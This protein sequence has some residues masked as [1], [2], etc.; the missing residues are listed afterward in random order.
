M[1]AHFFYC[2]CI[3]KDMPLCGAAAPT[4]LIF[5]YPWCRCNRQ[6]VRVF[7]LCHGVFCFATRLQFA[8]Q[9][10][11]LTLQTKGRLCERPLE[12]RAKTFHKSFTKRWRT[13]CR[14]CCRH[15]LAV[16]V[17][18]AY[19]AAKKIRVLF[20]RLADSRWGEWF[21]AYLRCRK[22][23]GLFSLLYE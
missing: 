10:V 7:Y 4:P 11:D 18:F 15:N 16:C 20:A 14:A 17:F 22:I 9:I 3:S 2:R 12:T 19:L 1:Y 8:K 13:H 5:C 21:F 23:I 6:F